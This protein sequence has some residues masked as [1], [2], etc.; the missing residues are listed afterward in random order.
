M[1]FSIPW[2]KLPQVANVDALLH[3]AE[4]CPYLPS[5]I[6]LYHDALEM[7][8]AYGLC[9]KEA[10]IHCRLFYLYPFAIGHAESA[11]LA[12]PNYGEVNIYNC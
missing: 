12:D 10:V 7:C 1:H 11:I 9:R 5:K 2:S 6:Q 8:K 4:W 3:R